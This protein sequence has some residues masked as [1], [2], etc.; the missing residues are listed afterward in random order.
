MPIWITTG[1]A[2]P[3]A[4]ACLLAWLLISANTLV[5]LPVRPGQRPASRLIWRAAEMASLLATIAI[6]LGAAL[7]ISEAMQILHAAGELTHRTGLA[8]MGRAL[9]S[10]DISRAA[11]LLSAA[12]TLSFLARG[13]RATFFRR[14]YLTPAQGLRF[15]AGRAAFAAVAIVGL[16]A[17]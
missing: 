13:H 5:R 3:A 4:A 6:G 7:A 16:L 9:L 15:L 11:L 10:G 17:I 1:L 14:R 2:W 8:D 12:I